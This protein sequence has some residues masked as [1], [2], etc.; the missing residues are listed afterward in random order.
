MVEE[1]AAAL[2][3]RSIKKAA[4]V[5]GPEARHLDDG[6]H[7]ARGERHRPARCG[8]CA[9]RRA[10]ARATIPSVAPRA[11][12]CAS[13]RT[14]CPSR[15]RRSRARRV[16]VASV[17]TAFPERPVAARRQARRRAPRGRVRRRRDR[18][19]HRPR[20]HALRRL[21]ARSS[22]RS[23]PTKEA[24]GA[25]HLK[26]I[27]ETGELGTLRRRPQGE[28]D[29]D[30]SPA[31]TSSRRRTGKISPPPRSPVTLVM[32]EAI[33]DY[34]LR[35]RPPHRDEARGR[36]PHREA[37]APLPRARQGDARRRVAHA[38]SLPLRRV[39]LLNDVLMQLEKERTGE[40]QAATTSPKD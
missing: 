11:R 7:H 36:H 32:L 2:A 3:K 1:R 18:H 29:R 22:T 30:R 14:W 26:V 19:G 23:P 37:G 38:G 39:A 25:A 34:Y 24:C 20:R 4:K 10:A 40:Y 9:R 16:K 15:R 31:A 28:R 5:A 17:A 33:R 12:R 6:P 27:L 8:S 13:I 21:R 35:D